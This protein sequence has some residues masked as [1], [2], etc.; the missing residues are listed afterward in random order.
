M[1]SQI[2]F[3]SFTHRYLLKAM[4]AVAVMAAGLASIASLQ[5]ETQ[6]VYDN[7]MPS[8]A[9]MLE[10]VTPAVVNIS[11]SRVERMPDVFG[12]GS[13]GQQPP[14]RRSRGAGSGVVIDS[15]DGFIIT[16]HHV[17]AGADAITVG[18]LDGRVLE[19]E[20]IGSDEQTDIALLQVEADRLSAVELADVSR[21]RIGDYVVAIGNPFGIGQTVTSGIISALGRA[22]INNDNYEDFIQTD[23]AIN[24]G[25][26]GGAL[27][28][29]QGRL[30]GI[31]TAI[32][33]GSGTSS[34]VGFAVPVDMVAA[35]VTHLERD[36]VVRRGQLG[37]II[38]DH[39]PLVEETL[40]LGAERGALIM[41]V[42]PGSVADEVGL[43]VSDLVVS[44][45]GKNIVGSRELRNAVGLAGVDQELELGILRDGEPVSVTALIVAGEDQAS[46]ATN[47][48][49]NNARRADETRFLGARLQD[50]VGAETGVEIADVDQRSPAWAA[51]L[52]PGDIVQE[53]N[54][55]PAASL[56]EF[57]RL[58][59]KEPE[60][61][62]LGVVRGGQKLL[63]IL[64]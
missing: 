49:P 47:G 54:R 34:G 46:V 50:V 30:V 11:V 60:V 53:V 62:A 39:T 48:E 1:T 40:E 10:T 61:I 31:N 35:V 26:S 64:S 22:G 37:V 12:F 29:L 18:L 63:V 42:M 38:R 43:Q 21:L 9:P 4:L 23:A 28:D 32:I 41:Q 15:E 27:V 51:G 3:K 8:L 20:L 33:S 59:S 5:A 24:V 44:I 19:A 52:R 7:S 25:N 16:N 56:S 36:G 58:L 17:V 6:Q 14:V 57:N 2:R 55:Q 45:N 13:N